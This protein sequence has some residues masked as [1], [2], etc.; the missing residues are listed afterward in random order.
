LSKIAI[1]GNNSGSGT[2]TL[3]SPNSSTDRTLDLPD[4]SGVIDRLNRAG[5]VL[6]VVNAT[7]STQTNSTSASFADTGLSASITPTS[8][9]SKIL[10]FAIISGIFK[11]ANDTSVNL[12]LVRGASNLVLF[13]RFVAGN[14]AATTNL[15]PSS[16]VTYLDS[17]ATTS[18][19]TYK[20]QFNNDTPS[21]TV[22]VQYGSST[23]PASSITL[24]E[25]AA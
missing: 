5:N 12:Y 3:A 15:V 6:Q 1:S 18:S 21:G 4:A 25:I 8:A 24:M 19:T 14:A 10:V 23:F 16:S 20:V 7:Y 9:T 22:S 11:S 13:G 2:F 17:P